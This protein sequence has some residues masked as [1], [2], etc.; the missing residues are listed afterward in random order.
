MTTHQTI[1]VIPCCPAC[2]GDQSHP[3]VLGSRQCD[4]CGWR[5]KV[6]PDGKAEH[7]LPV[8]T[9]GHRKRPRI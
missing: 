8:F 5:F 2:H 4:R 6:T 1:E 3:D 7:W 9:A